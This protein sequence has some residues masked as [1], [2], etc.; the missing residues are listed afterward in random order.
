MNYNEIEK[1]YLY[2]VKFEIE[3]EGENIIIFKIGRTHNLD[4]RLESLKVEFNIKNTLTLLLAI[5]IMSTKIETKM[6]QMFIK[7]YPDLKF[8]FKVKDILKT[9]C[10]KYN[11]IFLKELDFIKKDYFKQTNKLFIENIVLE[12]KIVKHHT[13]LNTFVQIKELSQQLLNN[14]FIV[15]EYVNKIYDLYKLGISTNKNIISVS[16]YFKNFKKTRKP[17]DPEGEFI[18]MKR[19]TNHNSHPVNLLIKDEYSHD[20]IK[21]FLKTHNLGSNNRKI[22]ELINYRVI[23]KKISENQIR[24][25]QLKM[26]KLTKDEIRFGCNNI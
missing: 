5:E 11:D 2:F 18:E 15:D 13:I 9:E 12:I 20:E 21:E 19:I 23:T 26:I 6:L 25:F 3:Y 10:F 7:K 14:N 17:T 4:S 8:N 22:Y 24:I 1:M 16:R